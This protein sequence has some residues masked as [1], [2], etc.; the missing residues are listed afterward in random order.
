MSGKTKKQD[1]VAD[2][3]ASTSAQKDVKNQKTQ[4]VQAKPAS[5]ASAPSVDGQALQLPETAGADASAPQPDGSNGGL[6][7]MP[8]TTN[9]ITAEGS[10]LQVDGDV[11]ITASGEAS[12]LTVGNIHI[13]DDVAVLEV[14]AIPENGFHRAGR[15]WPHDTVHVFVSD[16][17]DAQVPQDDQ[18]NPLHGCV[19][20]TVDAARLKAEKM[21]IVTELKPVHDA[22]AEED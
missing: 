19:I 2:A 12:A 15:F 8:T 4:T 21:L 11:V 17:P 5:L 7:I 9:L 3:A 16:D 20:S 13:A 6:T 22:G 18:G 10:N 14:R 1:S